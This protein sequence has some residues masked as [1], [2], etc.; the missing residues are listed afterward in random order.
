MDI[1]SA[2]PLLNPEP[3]L[4]FTQMVNGIEK[5]KQRELT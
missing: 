1:Y 3:P 2:G 5:L 4:F